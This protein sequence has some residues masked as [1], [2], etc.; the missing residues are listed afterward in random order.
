MVYA[1]LQAMFIIAAERYVEL[2]KTVS[3]TPQIASITLTAENLRKRC[4]RFWNEDCKAFDTCY[5]AQLPHSELVQSLMLCAGV[6][7]DEQKNILLNK[8]SNHNNDLTPI[9]LSHS[10]YKYQA[11]MNEPQK[12]ADFVKNDIANIWGNMLFDGA[13]TFW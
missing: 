10:I 9:T 2:C 11:L 7:T 8:L 5:D 1:P 3:Y 4:Q 13:T 12:Y 6:A